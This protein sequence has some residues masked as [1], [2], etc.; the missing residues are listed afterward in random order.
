MKMG[1][2][3]IDLSGKKFT[4]LIVIEFAG[5]EKGRRAALWRCECECGEVVVVR[6]TTLKNGET[7]SCGCLF[8]ELNRESAT[9]GHAH[10][11][12]LSP[13][14]V[15][16]RSM[17]ARCMYPSIRNFHRW[18]GRGITVCKRWQS[19]FENFLAD[20]GPRPSPKHSID[21]YPDPDGN[22]EPGNCRWATTKEQ[23]KNQRRN[24][25]TCE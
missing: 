10:A 8:I 23:R 6:A 3:T 17:R 18:G 15:S 25:P 4:R 9:H 1:P 13:E 11:N 12:A 16:W 7:R 24:K 2:R 19:S 20:M 21:R 5:Y 22:Y 14:Y